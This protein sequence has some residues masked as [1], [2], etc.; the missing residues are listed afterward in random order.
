MQTAETAGIHRET[1]RSCFP[2]FFSSEVLPTFGQYKDKPLYTRVEGYTTRVFGFGVWDTVSDVLDLGSLTPLKCLKGF[3]K[4]VLVLALV[5]ALFNWRYHSTFTERDA[6]ARDLAVLHPN[7]KGPIFLHLLSYQNTGSEFI[8][9]IFDLYQDAFYVHDPLEM[10][11][12]SVFGIPPN[13]DR[14]LPNNIFFDT[15]G[16]FR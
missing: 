15:E 4:V 11:Y 3:A 6:M 8:G 1:R 7:Y 2:A 13:S 16:E 14:V 5:F 10:V 12:T 9:K